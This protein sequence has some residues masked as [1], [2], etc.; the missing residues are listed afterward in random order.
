MKASSSAIEGTFNHLTK[1]PSS[2]DEGIFIK[3]VLVLRVN[4]SIYL[5]WQ[6]FTRAQ[7]TNTK[8]NTKTNKIEK[9]E[10][11]SCLFG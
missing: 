6:P 11:K 5:G 4:C 2:P 10:R 8:M 3:T 7:R 1:I 9:T